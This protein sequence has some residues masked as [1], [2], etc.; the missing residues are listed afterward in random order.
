MCLWRIF[1]LLTLVINMNRVADEVPYSLPSSNQ[2]EDLPDEQLPFASEA[3][4]HPDAEV[5]FPTLDIVSQLEPCCRTEKNIFIQNRESQTKDS[6]TKGKS[7]E[8]RKLIG[9]SDTS[10]SS[11]KAS[12]T[13]AVMDA[14]P[15]EIGTFCTY[16][17]FLFSN[18]LNFL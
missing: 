10:S 18:M 12:V 14:R 13:T 5:P 8:H 6:C 15:S 16:F 4:R 11:G 7:I 1:K 9:D 2:L 17:H 3:P